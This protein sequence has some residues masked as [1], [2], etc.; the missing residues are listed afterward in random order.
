MDAWLQFLLQWWSFV[1]LTMANYLKKM[2]KFVEL[3]YKFY[4]SIML[5]RIENW[6]T[7]STLYVI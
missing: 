1:I 7:I 2:A 5:L 6:M 3:L 4:L